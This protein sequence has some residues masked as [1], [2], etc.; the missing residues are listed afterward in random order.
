MPSR[1]ATWNRGTGAAP[2]NVVSGGGFIG[3]KIHFS[4]FSSPRMAFAES[5]L[6]VLKW[7]VIWFNVYSAFHGFCAI[8]IQDMSCWLEKFLLTLWW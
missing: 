1:P 3:G 2:T 6:G 5:K 8:A 4:W 7:R